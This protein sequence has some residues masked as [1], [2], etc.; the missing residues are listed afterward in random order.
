MARIIRQTTIWQEMKRELPPGL[1]EVKVFL[2]VLSEV[3][4][5]LVAAL[6]AE[7]G[8]GRDDYP[9]PAM[10]NLVAMGMFLRRSRF[11]EL[12]AELRRNSD[13]ARV[14]GFEE[15]GPNLYQIARPWNLSRFHAKLKEPRYQKL[16]EE[17]HQKTVKLLSAEEPELGKDSALDAS[18]VRTHAR[19]GRKDPEGKEQPSSDPEAS[20][21][22]KTKR[23]EDSQG[24]QREETQSTFGY[25]LYAAVDTKV[26]A[27]LAVQTTTGKA[28]DQEMALPM[29]DRAQQN[30][31]GGKI[32]TWSMDKGFDSTEN[33]RGCFARGVAPIV[34]V[35]DVPKNLESLPREDRE[36]P[37]DAG[38][39]V[40]WDRYSGEVFCYERLLSG[41]VQRRPMIYAGFEA[42]RET[43][44]F[45]CPLGPSAA[46]A[47]PAFSTCCAGSSGIQG[48]QVRIPMKTD[49]R[50]FA[51]VYPQ[52]K[53]WK[54]LYKGRT[55]AERVNSYVKEVL[56]LEDHCLRG[57][58]AISVRGLL[59]CITL[60]VRTLV[61][62][63]AMKDQAQQRAA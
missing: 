36:V 35:R 24:R 8:N 54:R 3:D 42:S 62:L 10:W 57:K 39:N 44:K 59:A 13:L 12:L 43:H 11:S 18:D 52:S 2:G 32:E 46:S 37:L 41:E 63:R 38:G 33:V 4:E 31:G 1:Q 51:P 7:R 48:R 34:P 55:A 30:L 19:P 58:A 50:R 25:K 29:L 6:M 53:R 45:R 16:L 22:V 14:L 49:Y 60:N 47:C 17:V 56:R 26:P 15:I 21:S 20:W 9:V 61:A 28:S 27:V 40:V 23:W 5:E